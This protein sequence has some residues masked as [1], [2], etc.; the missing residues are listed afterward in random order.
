MDKGTHLNNA[1]D[2]A[3]YI[4]SL[5]ETDDMLL[6]RDSLAMAIIYLWNV[7][8]LKGSKTESIAELEFFIKL[9]LEHYNGLNY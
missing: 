3:V 4:E 8:Q 6:V 1:G 2:A 5:K 7:H 9:F